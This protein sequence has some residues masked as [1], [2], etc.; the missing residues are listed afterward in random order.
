MASSDIICGK[1]TQTKHK[2][3]HDGVWK[4]MLLIHSSHAQSH[5]CCLSKCSSLK[6]RIQQQLKDTDGAKSECNLGHWRKKEREWDVFPC[7]LVLLFF[8]FFFLRSHSSKTVFSFI[9]FS[10]PSKLPAGS[11]MWG[12]SLIAVVGLR[13][14]RLFRQRLHSPHNPSSFWDFATMCKAGWL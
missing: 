14:V 2:W 6:S 9:A 10:E 11:F 7:S 8:F 4:A 3:G 13:V 12:K 5:H 1:N